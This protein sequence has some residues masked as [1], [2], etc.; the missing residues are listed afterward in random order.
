[1]TIAPR[2]EIMAMLNTGKT[3]SA[4]ARHFT[5][6]PQA[7]SQA[8]K[9]EGSGVAV[10]GVLLHLPAEV[11]SWLAAETPPGATISDMIR[12]IITDAHAEATQ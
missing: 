10:R 7:I 9:R 12:A 8:V 11:T 1:M 2:H 6:T 4:I 5:V 3:Q